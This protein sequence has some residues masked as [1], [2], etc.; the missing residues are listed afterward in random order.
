ME[1]DMIHRGKT[2]A[3]LIE[4]NELQ[5]GYGVEIGVYAGATLFYLLNRFPEL[6]M[7]AV[8]KWELVVGTGD[9]A[10]GDPGGDKYDN[11]LA[12]YIQ[13]QIHYVGF[14]TMSKCI[15]YNKRVGV[16]KVDSLLA[17]QSQPDN[18]F[19]FIFIDADHRESFVRADIA[20]WMPKL[21]ENGILA[22]HDVHRRTVRK[23]IDDMLPGWKE[24]GD[25]HVWYVRKSRI[26]IQ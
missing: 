19:D 2:L 23:A 17:A 22:G 6:R 13:R 14:K 12:T 26:C 16:L 7:L 18:T 25:D 3:N 15:Q 11:G 9:I 21:K 8:D 4:E 20:V 24:I 1:K 5:S 10:I